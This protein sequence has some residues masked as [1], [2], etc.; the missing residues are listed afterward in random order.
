MRSRCNSP[1]LPDYKYYGGKGITVCSEW[2]EY[3]VFKE[4]CVNNG[5]R[6]G[7]TI[8]R[9]DSNKGY[10]PG[11]CQW[12]TRSKNSTKGGLVTAEKTKKLSMWEA[13][14]I[15]DMYNTGCY[16]QDKLSKLYKVSQE[17]IYRIVNKYSYR[18]LPVIIN[19]N[20]QI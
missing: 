15:R 1:N 5:Y 18:K 9:I 13:E 2:D 7:L 6:E 19:A 16:S 10:Y 17:T 3:L 11:N 8:D 14:E 12:I 4:W 20:C